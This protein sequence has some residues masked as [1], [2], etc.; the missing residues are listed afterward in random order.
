MHKLKQRYSQ[1]VLK[2]NRKRGRDAIDD[3]CGPLP[4]NWV[5]CPRKATELIAGVFLAFKTPLDSKFDGKLDEEHLFHP[6]MLL[7]TTKSRNQKLGLWIDLTDSERYYDR[8]I[9]EKNGCKYVKIRCKRR[10]EPPSADSMD[11]FMK[12]CF[13]FLRDNPSQIIGVHCTHGFN[14]T[15]FLITCYLVSELK[16]TVEAA[17]ALFAQVRAPGIYK[18]DY[19]GELFRLYGDMRN[20]PVSPVR[21]PWIEEDRMEEPRIKKR[22]AMMKPKSKSTFIAGVPNVKPVDDPLKKSS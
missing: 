3:N 12:T 6:N 20:V 15:G 22:R 5:N 19:V 4:E 11:R 14:R 8:R 7:P 2:M 17:V 16:W 18:E 21:P 1:S 10:G 9:I 13:K